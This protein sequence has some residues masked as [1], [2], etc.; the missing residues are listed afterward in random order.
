[1][2]GKGRIENLRPPWQKGE[3]GNP[4]GRPQR[5]PIEEAILCALTRKEAV[6]VARAI[7]KRATK[8]DVRAFVALRDTTDGR[9]AQQVEL[10]GRDG[11]QIELTL[12][13]R[14]MR[15]RERSCRASE[16][17]NVTIRGANELPAIS[18]PFH[19]ESWNLQRAG[20]GFFSRV[21]GW[22]LRQR[23]LV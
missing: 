17:P 22:S 8:G 11:G 7:I 5:K 15:A 1:M 6:A 23:Q 12:A 20:S 4:A 19:C 13:E 21:G 3:S 16:E 10:S 2:A 18:G 14:L 9:P